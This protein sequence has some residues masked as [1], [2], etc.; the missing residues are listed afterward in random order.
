MKELDLTKGRVPSVLLRFALPFLLANLLQALYGGADLLIV[1]QTDS[2]VGVAAVAIGS[3]V[4]QTITGIVL[5]LTTGVTVCVAIAVGAADDRRAA[6]I[7][8]TTVWLFLGISAALTLGMLCA[9]ERITEWMHTPAE[10]VGQTVQYLWIC[11]L[12]ILFIVGYNAA[13]GIMRGLGDSRTPLAIVAVA[14]AVNI[15]LDLLF[16]VGMGWGAAGAAAATIAAQGISFLVAVVWLWRRGFAFPFHRSDLA[17]NGSHV[18]RILRLGTPIAL[19]DALINVSFLLIT[20]IINTMGVV[21]SAAV[22]VVEKLIVF[23]M[24]PMTAFA[25][26]V[27]TMTAQNYGAG[28][29]QRMH[30]SLHW[31]IGYSLLFG[32]SV[33]IYAQLLPETLTRL[34]TREPAVIALSADYLRSYSFDCILVSF[35][36][37]FN[38]FFSG[39]GNSLFPMIHSLIA[40]FVFR[41]PLS[42]FFSL[43]GDIFRIGWAAPLSTLVSLLFCIV[44]LRFY[45]RRRTRLPQVRGFKGA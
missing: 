41:I 31:G 21:A 28:R 11:S 1:G 8:G 18:L 16:V 14:C 42:Y 37:C 44:Y 10:A 9:V 40:T 23:A 43:S 2:A 15:A 27:S 13:C 17:W 39:Q 12:G 35:V 38:A 6:R 20:A 33:C 36:F 4:M 19:Q 34:F 3:Q 45:N 30:R 26:A 7:I 22:G 24:L 29:P 25:A 5:G 32:L